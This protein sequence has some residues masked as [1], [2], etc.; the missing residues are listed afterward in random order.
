MQEDY[1]V[2][3][4]DDDDCSENYDNKDGKDQKYNNH[5]DDKDKQDKHNHNKDNHAKVK[6]KYINQYISLDF[7]GFFC[8]YAIFCTF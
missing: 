2:N 6:K 1:D 3:A 8:F 7:G 5:K 4:N